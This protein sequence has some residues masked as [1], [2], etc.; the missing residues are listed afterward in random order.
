MTGRLADIVRHPIK[1]IGWETLASVEL[2]A[3]AVLPFDRLWAVAHEAAAFAGAPE[4]WHAKRNFVRGVAGPQLMAI[5]ARLDTARMTLRLTHPQRGEIE[6]DPAE[7]D[8]S[9]R[10]IAWL[11]PLWPETRP[12]AARLVNAAPDQALTDVPDPFVSVLNHSSR[13]ALGERAGSDLSIHR[14][15]GN[16]WLDG[17]APWEE[18]DWIGREVRIGEARLRVEERITRCNATKVNPASGIPDVDTLG[19]LEEAYGHRDFGVYARVI[20]SGPIRTG[21]AVILS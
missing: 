8:D 9:T 21:E 11:A 17:F 14:F 15:R 7:P 18:F 16:L 6:I 19:I 20:E 4:G 10:L 13:R 5:E 12:A 3:G 2:S 1:S